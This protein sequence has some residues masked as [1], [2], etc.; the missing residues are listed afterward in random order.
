MVGSDLTLVLQHPPSS[1]GCPRAPSPSLVVASVPPK[2]ANLLDSLPP[3]PPAFTACDPPAH[4][5]ALPQKTC[6]GDERHLV[7]HKAPGGA[8]SS[9]GTY[10]LVY[11]GTLMC[12]RLLGQI[13]ESE[14]QDLQDFYDVLKSG[15]SDARSDGSVTGRLP[16][17]IEFDWENLEVREKDPTFNSICSG[18]AFL[19]VE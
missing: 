13:G 7:L 9:V 2:P 15:A 11:T 8:R 14:P 3:P 16:C 1:C 5:F 18:T 17:P 12:S 10:S 4:S 19:C 6:L